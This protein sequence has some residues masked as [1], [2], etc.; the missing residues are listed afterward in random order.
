MFKKKNQEEGVNL[1]LGMSLEVL[2]ETGRTMFLARIE[3]ISENSLMLVNASGGQ[4][5]PVVYNSVV[6]L[7]VIRQD[8]KTVLLQGIIKGSSS[9]FWLIEDVRG[10]V[11]PGRALFRQPVSVKAA[12]ACV[13]ST[14]A[15]DILSGS[16]ENFVS[17]SVLDVSGSG[18]RLL[19]SERYQSGDWLNIK[20]L[21]LA[22]AKGDFSLVCRVLRVEQTKRGTY[23]YGC[24][25]ENMS[26]REQDRLIEAIFVLQRQDALYRPSRNR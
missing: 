18:L 7:R 25:F 3:E 22:P 16:N 1:Q 11:R 13:N 14:Y 24:H 10:Y 21:R 5:P 17:C 15:P 12:V 23:I 4:V 8:M 19:S 9:R 2:T 6:Q 26:Q 20:D